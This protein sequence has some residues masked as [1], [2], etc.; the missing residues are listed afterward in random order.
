[1]LLQKRSNKEIKWN[2]SQLIESDNYI[3]VFIRALAQHLS[4]TDRQTVYF[5]SK[6]FVDAT[7]E[8]GRNRFLTS[9]Y[10]FGKGEHHLM[11]TQENPVMHK[12]LRNIYDRSKSL[13]FYRL[14]KY[15]QAVALVYDALKTNKELEAQGFSFMIFDRI[16]QFHNL[17]RLYF[18]QNEHEKA[19]E[20]LSHAICFL[21]TGKA[22]PYLDMDGR[23][24]D[25]VDQDGVAM[26]GSLLCQFLF[27][28]TGNLLR[29]TNREVFTMKS[30][31]FMT[32][33]FD[34]LPCFYC[35]SDTDY[36]VRQWI[37]T[38][39]SFYLGND[40]KFR[41][42]VIAFNSKRTTFYRSIPSG[43]LSQYLQLIKKE[44]SI[45]EKVLQVFNKM[46]RKEKD[47]AEQVA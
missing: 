5:I 38:V 30:K 8:V 44:E 12:F 9:D 25:K 10:F 23:E 41:S 3:Q 29:E 11:A 43:L 18:S 32:K 34:A 19:L 17:S 14:G 6:L 36:G 40:H 13:Y 15:D 16:S 22:S 47:T 7:V 24:F 27:E 35:L 45:Y 33:I 37:E 46:F 39:R 2:K 4:A 31:I 26:R 21:M 42:G 20:I 1:M 28:T